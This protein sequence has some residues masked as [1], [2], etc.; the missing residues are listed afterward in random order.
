M[1]MEPYKPMRYR[2]CR[3]QFTTFVHELNYVRKKQ[4][5]TRRSSSAFADILT[6]SFYHVKFLTFSYSFFFASKYPPF[7]FLPMIV[8]SVYS[9]DVCVSTHT[10]TQ[11]CSESAYHLEVWMLFKLQKTYFRLW[12]SFRGVF[13]YRNAWFMTCIFFLRNVKMV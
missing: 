2:S 3:M 9:N 8:T 10:Y 13:H 12:F 5:Y 6:S 11:Q 1:K 4:A 7:D